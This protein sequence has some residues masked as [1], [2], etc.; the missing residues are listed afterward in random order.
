MR[1]LRAILHELVGVLAVALV[2][3]AWTWAVPYQ[4]GTIWTIA[5]L[6]MALVVITGVVRLVRSAPLPKG[7]PRG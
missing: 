7:D 6:A 1:W 5:Y 4:A 2:A 3:G